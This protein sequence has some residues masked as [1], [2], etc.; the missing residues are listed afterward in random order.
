MNIINN[1]MNKI[2]ILL[3]VTGLLLGACC[4]EDFIIPAPD[5]DFIEGAIDLTALYVASNC[6]ADAA[7]STEGATAD[8]EES[9][10]GGPNNN[11]WFKFTASSSEYLSLAV[12]VGGVSGTQNETIVT[13][14]DT[15]GVTELD[16][17]LYDFYSN[18]DVYLTY[19]ALISGETY[20]IS[21]DTDSD[22]YGTFTMC[23]SDTD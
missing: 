8:G 12:L 11:R 3:I 22:T 18:D 19:G 16:C 21:V 17:E 4:K 6:S 5:Y 9:S 20:Y 14:W 13:L 15:D 2:S 23:L 10:C 1:T 7:Y